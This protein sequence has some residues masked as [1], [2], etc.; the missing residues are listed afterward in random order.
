MRTF[1]LICFGVSS[2]KMALLAEEALIFV[3]APCSPDTNYT[4]RRNIA[5]KTA[6][7]SFKIIIRACSKIASRV[8]RGP[9]SSQILRHAPSFS[10]S[11]AS[12]C[13]LLTFSRVTLFP[14]DIQ[15]RHAVFCSHTAALRCFL[16]TFSRGTRE[17]F[18]NLS[19]TLLSR[20]T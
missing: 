3:L 14:A 13:F 9:I 10:D 17:V 12:R 20:V 18:L 2:R 7:R 8:T 19:P 16:L 6:I 5:L 1:F 4:T 15:P 11:A